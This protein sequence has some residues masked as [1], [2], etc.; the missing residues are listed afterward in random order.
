MTAQ[1]SIAAVRAPSGPPL[2]NVAPASIP[3]AVAPTGTAALSSAAA[4]APLMAAAPSMST[5]S[6]PADQCEML[7]GRPV[8]T[9]VFT[10]R[11]QQQ[12]TTP[13]VK[14]QSATMT[15]KE[16]AAEQKAEWKRKNGERQ[17]QQ[18][19]Q[20]RTLVPAVSH[21]PPAKSVGEDDFAAED[22]VLGELTD[23]QMIRAADATEEA[24]ASMGSACNDE[25]AGKRQRVGAE[26]FAT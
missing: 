7:F 20:H 10:G 24:V 2:A 18:Q 16:R 3:A 6:V 1:A 12:A 25:P 4:A 23:S 9:A 21:P 22:N 8:S 14:P 11:P 26:N 17:R 13:G 15:P 19:Q 5:A